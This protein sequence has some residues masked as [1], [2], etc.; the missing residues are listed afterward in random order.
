MPASTTATPQMPAALDELARS[1][2][3]PP[4][5]VERLGAFAASSDLPFADVVDLTLERLGGIVPAWPLLEAWNR[6][7]FERRLDFFVWHPGPHELG[8][9]RRLEVFVHTLLALA[10]KERNVARYRSAGVAA[11]EVVM[12]GD[13]CPI[14]V[15][16][17]HRVVSMTDTAQGLL[18][19]FH[20]GCRC[21]M[22][23]HLD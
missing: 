17:R 21:R 16:H 8:D 3:L 18:P 6:W 14:C 19:P 10:L 20:P 15:E 13:D 12:A 7:C 5:A 2:P 11:A 23:P 4:E 9:R 22:V 1:L